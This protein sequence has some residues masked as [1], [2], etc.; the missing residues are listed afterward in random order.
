M[1]AWKAGKEI[2]VMEEKGEGIQWRSFSKKAMTYNK[3][4]LMILWFLI[5]CKLS[6]ILHYPSSGN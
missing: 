2:E 3:N 4:I 6:D 1:E 5:T